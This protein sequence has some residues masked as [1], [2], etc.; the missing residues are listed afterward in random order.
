MEYFNPAVQALLGSDIGA[1]G[2]VE[3][4]RLA[5]FSR[6]SLDIDVVLDLMIHDLQILHALDGSELDDLRATG[7]QV[8]GIVESKAPP[9][10]EYNPDH[11]MSDEQGYIYRPNI[12]VVEEMANMIS[13]SRSYQ[14]NIEVIN[15]SKQMLIRTL[16]MGE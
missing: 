16:S 15:A 10:A 13:A 9:L 8:L 1:P 6:R 7:V 5:A 4:H 3:I 12:K 11:P 14:S 2:F